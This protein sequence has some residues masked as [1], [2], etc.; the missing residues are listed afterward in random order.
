MTSTEIESRIKPR[1]IKKILFLLVNYIESISKAVFFLNRNLVEI[2]FHFIYFSPRIDVLY[3]FH[4]PFELFKFSTAHG[5]IFFLSPS[6]PSRP[7]PLFSSLVSSLY[8][9]IKFYQFITFIPSVAFPPRGFYKPPFLTVFFFLWSFFFFS[10]VTVPLPTNCDPRFQSF[11]FFS[12]IFSS[13]SLIF[14]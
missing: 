7:F 13:F 11:I 6:P 10:K 8:F 1:Q 3:S 4:P 2:N 12:L 9:L 5:C 14:L